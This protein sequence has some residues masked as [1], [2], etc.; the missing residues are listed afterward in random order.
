MA[1]PYFNYGVGGNARPRKERWADTQASEGE[2]SL[3]Y[4][5]K[6]AE[7]DPVVSRGWHH[8]FGVLRR[9]E[10]DANN[11]GFTYE[12]P[13]GTLIISREQRHRDGMYLD[14]RRDAVTGEVYLSCSHVP[15][16]FRKGRR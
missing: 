2:V 1:H 14:A 5:P 13:D 7:A 8:T 15:R 3:T 12:M 9:P 10:L 6:T 4:K 16:I 11:A